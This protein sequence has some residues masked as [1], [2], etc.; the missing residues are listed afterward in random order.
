MDIMAGIHI[1]Y[2]FERRLT[3][4]SFPEKTIIIFKC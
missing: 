1:Y 3:L 2:M 4:I